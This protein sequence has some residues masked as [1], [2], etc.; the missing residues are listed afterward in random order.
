MVHLEGF[1]S[2]RVILSHIG[3]NSSRF[4]GVW[5]SLK[6]G[7]LVWS[8]FLSMKKYCLNIFDFGN[9]DI[10]LTN[11]LLLHAHGLRL[12]NMF[13]TRGLIGQFGNLMP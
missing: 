13:Q 3:T 2:I 12:R 1:Q 9:Q 8:S 10:T 11:F 7:G 5:E 4:E 6:L